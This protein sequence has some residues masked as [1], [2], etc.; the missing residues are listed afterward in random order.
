MPTFLDS[1]YQVL[2]DADR[3]MSYE[4][5]T[6]LAL[7][8]GLLITQGATPAATMSAQLYMNIIEKGAAS[9]FI[10]FGPNQFALNDKWEPQPELRPKREHE[11]VREKTKARPKKASAAHDLLDREIYSIQAFLSGRN[12]QPPTSEKI[13]DWVT[14]CYSLELYSEGAELFGFVDPLE[15][16]EWYYERTKKIARSCALRMNTLKADL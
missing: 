11:S 5:I 13:C 7:D 16:N 4:E 14:M 1:A 9:R 12:E 6:R 8:R 15:V 3:P 2:K 10:L